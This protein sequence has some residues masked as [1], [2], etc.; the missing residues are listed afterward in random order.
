MA[1]KGEIA[2]TYKEKE[3]RLARMGS[4]FIVGGVST[5]LLGLAFFTISAGLVFEEGLAQGTLVVIIG[6]SLM[7]SGGVT[8]LVLQ[9]KNHRLFH[10]AW[11][12]KLGDFHLFLSL[13][14]A[15]LTPDEHA[16]LTLWSDPDCKTSDLLD[17]GLLDG[18]IRNRDNRTTLW[19]V[20]VRMLAEERLGLVEGHLC[21]GPALWEIAESEFPLDNFELP[22]NQPEPAQVST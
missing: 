14:R 12:G 3:K 6:L 15:D 7:V 4:F 2:V 5:M 22:G 16:I 9:E 17:V 19:R 10:K 1:E 21:I 18:L 11:E 8:T 13:V 20:V